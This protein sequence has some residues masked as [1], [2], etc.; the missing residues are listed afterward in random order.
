MLSR[1]KL[2]NV[3]MSL[4][5]LIT[6]ISGVVDGAESAI[7]TK[8]SGGEDHT[9]VLTQSN[10][11]WSCGDNSYYQLGTGDNHNEWTLRRVKKGEMSTPSDY[12]EDID[13]IDAGWKH[14]LALDAGGFAC[15]WGEDFAYLN[16]SVSRCGII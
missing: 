6:V 4:T 15:N 14:S 16:N 2:I 5:I 10:S 9:L 13:D 11:V 1:K 12:L 3:T 7:P 8:V